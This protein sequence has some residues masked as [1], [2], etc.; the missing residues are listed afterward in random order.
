MKPK[1]VYRYKATDNGRAEGSWYGAH[2]IKDKHYGVAKLYN[3][4]KEDEESVVVSGEFVVKDK[5]LEKTLLIKKT[6][7]KQFLTLDPI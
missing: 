1:K 3:A 4:D 5:T 7:C 2:F 6:S